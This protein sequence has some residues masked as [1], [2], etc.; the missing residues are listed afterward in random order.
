MW[1]MKWRARLRPLKLPGGGS[2]AGLMGGLIPSWFSGGGVGG[3]PGVPVSAGDL[4]GLAG[5]WA[6]AAD[7][8]QWQSAFQTLLAQAA[9]SDASGP[10]GPGA[11]PGLVGKLQNIPSA[12]SH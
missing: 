6:G 11:D 7:G 5:S 12:L 10:G 8:G 4:T 1:S 9:A 2:I 3:G